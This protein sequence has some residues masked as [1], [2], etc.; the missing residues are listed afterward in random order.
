[1]ASA[2]AAERL[3][4][5]RRIVAVAPHP[6][7]ETYAFGGTLARASA[8]GAAV[9]VISATAGEKGE[10]LSGG[11]LAGEAL[12]EVRRAEL[13]AS[14]RALGAEA[15]RFLGLPDG[16]AASHVPAGTEALATAFEELAP[17]VVLTLGADGGYGH[18]DHL[19]TTEMVGG[20]FARILAPRGATLLRAIFPRGIFRAFWEEMHAQTP[21]LLGI[22]DPERLGVT[23]DEADLRID[24][25][26]QREAKLASIAA[27]HTQIHEGDPH[28]FIAP[29]VV[30]ALLD[31]EWFETLP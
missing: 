8:A 31:E 10:D 17:D 19:A 5:A 7:D 28:R 23:A 14:C 25:R 26:P 27:H 18:V 21:E 15:P 3:D 22:D 12:A 30:D 2:S 4:R 13:A 16:S 29:G 24:I 11:G 20:A 1:M 9:W 6:D